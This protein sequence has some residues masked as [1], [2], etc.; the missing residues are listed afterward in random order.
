MRFESHGVLAGCW[1][2]TLQAS[3]QPP[4]LSVVHRGQVVAEAALLDAGSGIWSVTAALPASVIDNGVHSLLLVGGDPGSPA[5]QAL[6]SLTLVAGTAAGGDL[7]A[8]VAQLRAELD[9]LKREFRRFAA[10]G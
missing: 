10:G 2:G 3:G 6:G 1:N 9:L 4:R 8:E 7:L 5:S